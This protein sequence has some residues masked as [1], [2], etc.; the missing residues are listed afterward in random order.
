[1][2]LSSVFVE[3][4]PLDLPSTIKSS[5]ALP[6]GIAGIMKDLY[7]LV[8]HLNIAVD[9]LRNARSGPDYRHVMDEVK[10]SLDTIRRYQNKKDL[11]RELLVE[12]SIIGNIDPAAGDN[13]AENVITRLLNILEE[14]YQIASKPVHTT[15]RGKIPSRFSMNPDRTDAIFVLTTALAASK[16]L[17][18]RIET[19]IKTVS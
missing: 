19:Y 18:E 6:S 10:S 14:V 11:G 2:K 8:E 9:D 17:I 5:S 1:M 15:L 12:T 4:F 3:L 16:F 13:A 7:T